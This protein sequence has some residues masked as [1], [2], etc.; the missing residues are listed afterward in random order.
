MMKRRLGGLIGGYT[1]TV[2]RRIEP[3][4]LQHVNQEDIQIDPLPM[5][6]TAT[7]ERSVFWSQG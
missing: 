7:L 3:C 1:R 4:G 5:N 6:D 2:F